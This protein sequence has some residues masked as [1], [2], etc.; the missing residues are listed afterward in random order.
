MLRNPTTIVFMV[1]PRSSSKMLFIF[2]IVFVVPSIVVMSTLMKITK[3]RFT[4]FITK[5]KLKSKWLKLF[6][7][8][9]F[10]ILS[11]RTYAF[12]SY[13]LNSL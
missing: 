12:L 4:K 9:K 2:N 8:V 7:D 6:L 1:L 11:F 5:S 10:M 13:P 3:M